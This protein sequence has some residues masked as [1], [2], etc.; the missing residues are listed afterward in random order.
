[1]GI[2]RR[3]VLM[4]T[5]GAFALLAG[6]LSPTFVAPAYAVTVDELMAPQ[7]LPDMTEGS[8]D[9]PVT[10]IEYASMTC[11]HCARVAVDTMPEIKKKYI[12]TGK[13]RLIFRE[14]PFD[15]RAAAAAML[16]RC[17]PKEQFFPL[18]DVLFKQPPIRAAA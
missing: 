8:E 9:A 1:M 17:A 10:I 15:P 12:D 5:L 13:V 6:T 3:Q 18:V 14:F 2:D 16:A 7:A 11:P 4:G